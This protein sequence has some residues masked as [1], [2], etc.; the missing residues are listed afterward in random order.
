MNKPWMGNKGEFFSESKMIR[1]FKIEDSSSQERKLEENVSSENEEKE[2]LSQESEL[3]KNVNLKSGG[4]AR[5]SQE[6]EY[7]K[8]VNSKNKVKARVSQESECKKNVNSKDEVKARVSQKSE[9]KKN[10]NSKDEVK[11]RVPQKSECKKNVNSED[12]VKAR[13]SQ[14]SKLDKNVN[15]KNKVEAMIL[16]KSKWKE[17][18][19]SKNEV[20]VR[21]LQESKWKGNVTLENER[22]D[23]SPPELKVGR[24]VRSIRVKI[25][26]STVAE[27]TDFLI[28]PITSNTNEEVFAFHNEM[29]ETFRE[30]D[31][32]LLTTVHHYNEQPYCR[33]I[34][35]K[36]FEKRIFIEF[37][38]GNSIKHSEKNQ[39][40]QSPWIPIHNLISQRKE[41]K[42]SNYITTRMPVEIGKYKTEIGLE[43]RVIFQE[44]V[45][46]I[47]E[48]S[49]EIILTDS[50]FFANEVLNA[51]ERLV[52]LKKG[53]LLA[54]GYVV[55]HI[56]YTVEFSNEQNDVSVRYQLLQ[57]MVLEL[58]LQVLQEQEVQVEIV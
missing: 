35:S 58:T 12:E 14:E 7:K 36:L 29:N 8:N 34:S 17:N 31:T 28:P 54:E 23:N 15:S 16:Q 48:I 21:V 32:K 38:S 41:K 39:L 46:E 57:K 30:L 42:I 47:K 52:R 13:V 4:K 25:P 53:K 20:K 45:V 22:R 1:K 6:S 10:V 33:L 24:V 19:N 51:K 9:C 56:E 37:S 5:L 18:I 3:D 40:E 11:A 27:V 55:Q 50:K 2:R 44:K 49:Q 26:F 43:E